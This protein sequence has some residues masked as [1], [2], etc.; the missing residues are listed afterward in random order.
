MRLWIVLIIKVKPPWISMALCPLT[1]NSFPINNLLAARLIMGSLHSL[2]P[3]NSPHPSNSSK[4]T[5]TKTRLIFPNHSSQTIDIALSKFMNNPSIHVLTT[6]LR[7]CLNSRTLASSRPSWR[8][9]EWRTCGL[10][11]RVGAFQE[12]HSLP[13]RQILTTSKWWLEGMLQSCT[14]SS[15]SSFFSKST[16]SNWQTDSKCNKTRN[17]PELLYNK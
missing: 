2:A 13:K 8:R 7:T 5:C 16:S 14:S 4:N 3:P 9:L 6:K 17:S 11:C 10:C 15:K 12:W 1:T